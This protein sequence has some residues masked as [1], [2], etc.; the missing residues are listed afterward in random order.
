MEKCVDTIDSDINADHNFEKQSET[1]RCDIE[2]NNARGHLYIGRAAHD[3]DVYKTRYRVDRNLRPSRLCTQGYPTPCAGARGHGSCV[4]YVSAVLNS[5]PLFVLLHLLV[6]LL[7]ASK[8]CFDLRAHNDKLH[9]LLTVFEHVMCICGVLLRVFAV[10]SNC[11]DTVESLEQLEAIEAAGMYTYSKLTR[12]WSVL[13]TLTSSITILAV[14]TVFVLLSVYAHLGWTVLTTNASLL[15][16]AGLHRMLM[17]RNDVSLQ[18]LTTEHQQVA[19]LESLLYLKEG[20]H[21]NAWLDS[22]YTQQCKRFVVACDATPQFKPL[23]YI[24]LEADYTPCLS[25]YVSSV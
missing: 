2:F 13:F 21:L 17:T 7:S 10:Y 1:L 22:K 11:R 4:D 23:H 6:L 3:H 19:L 24:S 25:L 16:I 12:Q 8:E 5:E 14:V 9:F 20:L 15:L 18:Q